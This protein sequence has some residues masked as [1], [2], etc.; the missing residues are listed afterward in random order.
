[1]ALQTLTALERRV[2]AIEGED[3]ATSDDAQDG[4]E[5]VCGLFVV[6]VV[7]GDRDVVAARKDHHSP[8]RLCDQF[9]ERDPHGRWV[10][11][12]VAGRGHP[13]PYFSPRVF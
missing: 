3:V 6:G 9:Y 7:R 11:R 10:K 12:V 13:G 2:S 1:M 5:R 4:D 8:S